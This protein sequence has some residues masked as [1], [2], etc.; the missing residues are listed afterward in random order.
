M[1]LKVRYPPGMFTNSL[2]STGPCH[3]RERK[4]KTQGEKRVYARV[5]DVFCHA[6][7]LG[8]VHMHVHLR[9]HRRQLG[10]CRRWCSG[11]G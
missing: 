8:K 11:S 10:G 1:Y 9:A 4:C 7:L 5:Q 3:V 6:R 2:S